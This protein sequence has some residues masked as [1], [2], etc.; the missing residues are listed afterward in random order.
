MTTPFISAGPLLA[1]GPEPFILLAMLFVF[2]IPMIGMLATKFRDF[3]Q[4]PSTPPIQRAA[5][6]P[7]R[8][9]S[10]IDDFLRRATQRRVADDPKQGALSAARAATVVDAELV[11]DEPIGDRVGRETQKFLD[12]SDF[13]LRSQQLG[14]KVAQ[15]DQQF[16]QQVQ[17]A[18]SGEVS[19]LAKRRGQAADA[20]V[21]LAPP[22][23]VVE[24]AEPIDEPQTQ[25]M[26]DTF[27]MFT[28]PDNFLQS[29]VMAEIMRRPN[30]E[31]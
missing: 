20:P 18:F 27:A 25:M 4:P 30:W 14:E 11:D 15:V 12:T 6:D 24:E 22:N 7:V 8:I 13:R 3:M 29:L 21:P 28:S 17:S 1:A 23:E 16:R 10:Q 2:V 31:D 26:N 19:T 5:S 9:Q